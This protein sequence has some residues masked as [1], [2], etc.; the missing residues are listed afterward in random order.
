M[1]VDET[2]P[3][4]GVSS[5][6]P[7]PPLKDGSKRHKR[8]F[9]NL[10]V[11]LRHL[12]ASFSPKFVTLLAT[13]YFF[14]KGSIYVCIQGVQLPYFKILG[15]DG[16]TY[17]MLSVIAVTPWAMKGVI[18]ALSDSFALWGYHK[19]YYMLLSCIWGAVAIAVLGA[20]P[21]AV[22]RGMLWLP[23]IL[24]FLVHYQIATLDLLCEGKYTEK[25]AEHP[26]SRS[27]VITFVWACI[28][29][30]SLVASCIVGPV[31]DFAGP[32][33]IF[34]LILPMSLHIALPVA[35]GFLPET[36]VAP[37]LTNRFQMDKIAA[38]G[39]FFIL[40]VVTA[41]G[42]LLLAIL[43]L[44]A[45]LLWQFVYSI[46]ASCVLITLAYRAMPRQLANCNLYM[47]IQECLYVSLAGAIDFWY[48][49]DPVHCV[50]GGPGFD[51]T[52]YQTYSQL[53][54]HTASVLGLWLFQVFMSSWKFRHVYWATT[55][56][57]VAA[58]LFDF[59]IV[60]RWN[61]THLGIGDRAMYL[62]G[63]AIV[64]PLCTMLNFMPGVILT[65]K[66]CPKTME[67]TVYAILAGFSNF[68]LNSAKT[69]GVFIQSKAGIQTQPPNCDFTRL[70]LLIMICHGLLPLLAVPLTFV[71]LPPV[72]MDEPLEKVAKTGDHSA[73]DAVPPPTAYELETIGGT[74][75]PRSAVSPPKERVMRMNSL[76]SSDNGSA[77]PSSASQ[78]ASRVL[79]VYRY[80][81]R[82]G[83]HTGNVQP[84]GYQ[85]II[86]ASTDHAPTTVKEESAAGAVS[87]PVQYVFE[88]DAPPLTQE[89]DAAAA[90]DGL[91]LSMTPPSE[92]QLVGASGDGAVC[93]LQAHASSPQQPDA[94]QH[95][96]D[97]GPFCAP[98]RQDA[99]YR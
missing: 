97:P 82:P 3:C 95:T 30:G 65:A 64:L 41:I 40:A 15:V 56:L 94:A 31:S 11:Y 39:P 99:P 80:L 4:V 62:I 72:R 50:P 14:L 27:D 84:G 44:L 8:S 12:S 59:I 87:L 57:R 48:T 93:H 28:T 66:L 90:V 75:G 51:Y 9:Y 63:D 92:E 43:S 33:L 58:S 52:Y 45:P 6:P 1:S 35:L 68:G 69:F 53:V 10:I 5:A 34:W 16:V 71:L 7:L 36:R 24:F 29:L 54:G 91:E 86:H 22:V 73:D 77:Y 55:T 46:A 18:G 85:P 70:P 88:G 61:V 20:L 49:A 42:A 83:G 13:N 37:E 89:T 81:S 23:P 47:Y 19:R 98:G 26:E 78:F 79:I 67:S 60:K 76:R 96:H 21:I 25:M 2:S 74:A 32:K 17:Q 38:E